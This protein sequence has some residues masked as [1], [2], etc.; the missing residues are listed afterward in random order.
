[1]SL[2]PDPRVISLASADCASL[3]RERIP[4]EHNS[5]VM[6]GFSATGAFFPRVG[7]C[8]CLPLVLKK[9]LRPLC[10]VE[11][12]VSSTLCKGHEVSH[13]LRASC[14]LLHRCLVPGNTTKPPSEAN[15]GG[16]PASHP[17]QFPQLLPLHAFC[18][19]NPIYF[20]SSL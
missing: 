11:M 3:S 6:K 14:F 17:W 10:S 5:W 4:S 9:C 16:S 7:R 18:V 20:I 2:K 12:V 13:R 19:S 8:S 15:R 1:M